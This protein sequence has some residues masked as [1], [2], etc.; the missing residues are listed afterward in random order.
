MTQRSTVFTSL[1][2]LAASVGGAGTGALGGVLMGAALAFSGGQP[3]A[4]AVMGMAGALCGVLVD[5]PQWMRALA[6]LAV[7]QTA[8]L[9]PFGY[10]LPTAPFPQALCGA[11]VSLA[12]PCGR[13]KEWLATGEAR[14]EVCT[15]ARAE[16]QLRDAAAALG[17]MAQVQS[18]DNEEDDRRAAR[19]TFAALQGTLQNLANGLHSGQMPLARKSMRL[20]ASVGVSA[21]AK[22]GVCGDSYAVVPLPDERMLAVICD[23]MGTGEAARAQSEQAVRLITRWMQAGVDAPSAIGAANAFFLWQ[24]SETFS[25]LDLAVI[26]LRTSRAELYKLAAPP[27]LHLRADAVAEITGAD[28]PIGVLEGSCPRPASVALRRGDTL[29][30]ASDGVMDL[31]TAQELSAVVR[32]QANARKACEA[33]VRAQKSA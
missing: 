11:L 33:V 12:L 32:A 8:Y 18:P 26:D 29:F 1:C 30:M 10:S 22:E 23:G 4:A 31:Y 27:S 16:R 13:I 17:E 21:R 2:T 19:Q 5:T 14:M 7:C 15:I 9:G 6:F 28:L 24:G 25:T 3:E 20:N